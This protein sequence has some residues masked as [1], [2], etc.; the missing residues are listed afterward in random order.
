MFGRAF[1]RLRRSPGKWDLMASAKKDML[2]IHTRAISI[3][4]EAVVYLLFVERENT[5]EV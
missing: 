1:N 2:S 3:T 4:T 5:G